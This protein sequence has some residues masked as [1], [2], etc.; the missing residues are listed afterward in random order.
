MGLGV[1]LTV[2]GVLP[3]LEEL[4]W[5]GVMFVWAKKMKIQREFW[6]LKQKLCLFTPVGIQVEFFQF[7]LIPAPQ[8]PHPEPG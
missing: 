1:A 7:P 6:H 8:N 2:K 5:S 4:S 3:T